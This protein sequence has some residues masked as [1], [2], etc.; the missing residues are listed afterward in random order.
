MDNW[1]KYFRSAN[2][3]IFEVIQNAI[4]IAASDWPQEFRAQRD[5]IA[6]KLFTCQLA[7]CHGCDRMDGHD[8]PKEKESEI[9][10]EEVEALTE[11]TQE[12]SR[13]VQEV[14]RIKDILSSKDHQ[15]RFSM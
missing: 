11:E 13:M 6:E 5:Q 1:R 12:D 8:P 10:A 9:G 4:I 14:F 15:V 3:D 7:K 2:S